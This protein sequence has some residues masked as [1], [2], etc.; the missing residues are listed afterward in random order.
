[1]ENTSLK[2]FVVDRLLPCVQTPAQYIGGE[3]N[4]VR[5]DHRLMRG[6]LCLAFPD[7]YTIGMSHHGLQ[8][9]YDVMNGRDDWACERAFTPLA[10]MEQLLR[11]HRLPLWS[12]ETFTPLGEF[13]VLGFTLQYDLCHSN[14]LTMLDLGGIPLAAEERTGEHP[15]VIAGGP[16]AVNPEPMARFIDL[17]VIGDGE[18]ALPELCNLWIELRQQHIKPR[19]V[20][21]PPHVP[22]GTSTSA[23]PSEPLGATTGRG[24]MGDTVEQSRR[25]REMLLAEMAARLPY[26]YV[27]RFYRGE[28]DGDGRP[29]AVR[30]MRDGVPERIEPAVAADLEAFPPPRA[31]VVPYVECVQDR[32]AIEIMRG[33]PGKCRFCQS[34]TIKRPLR[35]RK[36]DS[37]LQAA[38]QQYRSTGLNEISLLSLSTSDYPEF[39]EL[40]RRLQET[41]RPLG[42]SI[43][44]PSLRINEQ[45]RF[46]GELMNTDRHSGLTLAPETARDDM[47]RQIGKPITNEDL[48]AGC[49][50]AFENGF[51][52]VKLYFMCGLPG[53]R[54]TDLEGIIE[55]SETISRLGK[56]VGGQL[57]T[58]VANVS[59]FVPKP[60][61]PYQWNAMQRREYFRWAHEFLY[62]RKRLRSVQLKCHDIETS[63]L[64]GVMCRG[65]RRVG[66]A[67]EL[68]WRRGARF[69][70]WAEKLQPGL[71][72]QALADAGI[73]V[74]KTLHVPCP[75]PS[76]LPWDHINIRQGREYLQREEE[77]AMEQLVVDGE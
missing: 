56:E 23:I 69:D 31:P 57:A 22:T 32:I 18:E 33:C 50:K 27:P 77:Q 51:S 5:K 42:V 70:A 40:L 71:W 1:M 29:A 73:D 74:E 16:G 48:Y 49:R 2:Q 9:L 59:N 35:F 10:D 76:A 45:L 3:L 53:E 20:V 60:Q 55:M 68:A 44:L 13:D 43:A 54:E 65:G 66:E 19:P 38:M 30:P 14:V 36:V 4:A 41:F 47:R 17:F 28:F 15:L 11:E 67:I 58:V 12:L 21:A 75:A 72:W 8:V 61:T 34:T 52:R 63:L 7:A 24:F 26:V 6:T 64:E 62:R 39:D 46:V 37:I 25:E